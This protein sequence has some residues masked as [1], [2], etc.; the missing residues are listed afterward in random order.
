MCSSSLFEPNI[1]V[2]IRKRLKQ[3]PFSGKN[4]ISSIVSKNK[5]IWQIKSEKDPDR[6]KN[7]IMYTKI[8]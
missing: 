2:K 7:G 8:Q 1:L 5:R 6:D 4:V 3:K